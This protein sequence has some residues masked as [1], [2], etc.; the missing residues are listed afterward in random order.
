MTVLCFFIGLVLGMGLAFLLLRPGMQ[1]CGRAKAALERECAVLT[2]R[3]QNERKA[4]E[5]KLSVL[6]EAQKKLA[7]AFKG[8]SADALKNN[9]QVFLELAKSALGTFQERAKGD[10]EKR[11]QAITAMVQPV[12]ESLDKV[13][14]KIRQMETQRAGAYAS[15]TEQVRSLFETQNQLRVETSRL[16]TALRSPL[17]RGHWGEMQLKR[18]VELA[19]MVDRCDFYR[20]PSVTSEEGRFRPDLLVRLPGAK[21]II[22]DAKAPL[23]AYL[24]AIEAADE[25]RRRDKLKD[26][27][28]QVR[29]HMS[30]LRKKSYWEQFD[31]VPEFV[32]LFLPGECFFSAA[33]EQDP[34]LLE[35]DPGIILATPTTLIALLRA[36]AY[37]W[38][39]DNL[40][41]NALEISKL[42]RELYKRIVDTGAH[43]VKLGR[44]LDNAVLTY[45]KAVGSLESRVLVTARKFRE[46]EITTSGVEIEELIPIDKL[47]RTI[48]FAEMP[49]SSES[50]SD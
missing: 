6:N 13:D 41:Q 3:L 27:A 18:V 14:D 26:H 24:E 49:V 35:F 39:Q 10:L 25:N 43:W 22:I 34:S 40:T 16:V 31:P 50:F 29:A 30:A 38:K 12:R 36:V 33:L 20:Q 17:A 1:A 28:R 11:Q 19:G 48:Q 23:E 15:L 46:L 45:N 8:L 2:E 37:A 44:S 42:G 21:S 47:T 32:V 4:A 7:E 9:N 5:D